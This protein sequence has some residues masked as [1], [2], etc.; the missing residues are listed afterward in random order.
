M[1]RARG[2][3]ADICGQACDAQ[4]L[5]I[6]GQGGCSRTV[7]GHTYSMCGICSDAGGSCGHSL[8]TCHAGCA[9]AGTN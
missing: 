4:A 3:D 9:M 7:G 6:P 5:P 1:I 2:S 8:H